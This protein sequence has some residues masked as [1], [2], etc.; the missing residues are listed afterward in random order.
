MDKTCEQGTDRAGHLARLRC[1][2]NS[3]LLPDHVCSR[4]GITRRYES[5]ATV[6][7]GESSFVRCR[8]HSNL[9]GIA[10]QGGRALVLRCRIYRNG[11]DGILLQGKGR[12]E[13][14]YSRSVYDYKYHYSFVTRLNFDSSG[15]GMNQ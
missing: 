11:Q 6:D 3:H 4:T 9:F 15:Q 1:C 5:G 12:S 8:L 7:C 2:P 13:I 14:L 10:V